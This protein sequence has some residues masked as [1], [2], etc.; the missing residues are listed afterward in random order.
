MSATSQK[1]IPFASG[2]VGSL[3]RPQAVIDMLPDDPGEKSAD[4]S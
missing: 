4:A 1:D 3:P 2:V